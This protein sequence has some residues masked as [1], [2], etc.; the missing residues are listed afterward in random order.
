MNTNLLNGNDSLKDI[1]IKIEDKVTQAEKDRSLMESKLKDKGVEITPGSKISYM[2]NKI[3]EV[4]TGVEVEGIENLPAWATLKVENM[5]FNAASMSILRTGLQC[6]S[7]SD[8][9]YSLGGKA[10]LNNT[11]TNVNECYD[12]ISNTWTTK[13]NMTTERQLFTASVADN[14]IYCIGGQNSTNNNL[15]NNECYDTN[16]NT[17]TTKENMITER[18]SLTSSTVDN[19]IYC[20]AGVGRSDDVF[21][22]ECY[23]NNSNT[24]TSKQSLN[25][26]RFDCGSSTFDNKIYCIGGRNFNEDLNNNND[27]Y[28][29]NTDIWTSKANMLLAKHLM[30]I[31]TVNEKIYSIAGFTYNKNKAVITTNSTNQSYDPIKN[32]WNY[33]KSVENNIGASCSS[34]VNNNIYIMGA[35]VERDTSNIC[36]IP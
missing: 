4:K 10:I 28:D 36:Y 30:G 2:I 6:S 23:D 31:S 24:W 35:I 1:L 29:T 20:I 15:N 26:I 25:I 8:K 17:W 18:Y 33:N 11:Y 13:E 27:C 14:K 16:S 9:I 12:T 5:Y 3:D 19:K 22:N 32:E 34:V 21:A 7:I